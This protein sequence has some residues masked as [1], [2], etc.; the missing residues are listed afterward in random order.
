MNLLAR[1]GYKK[2]GQVGEAITTSIINLDPD[3]ATEAQ[4]DEL[5][6]KFKEMSIQLEE[7]NQSLK[8]EQ[9]EA[10]NKQKEYDKK[11]A[12]AMLLQQKAADATDPDL[13]ASLEKSLS[14]IVGELEEM[15]AD[16]AREKQEADDALALRDQLNEATEAMAKNLKEVRGALEQAKHRNRA[17]AAR[18]VAA[19]RSAEVAAQLA[20]IKQSGSQF[21]K[22]LN[23]LNKTADRHEAAA[24]AAATRANLL[25]PASSNDANIEAAMR[26]AGGEP[27]KADLAARL[28][29]L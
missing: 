8:K 27:P 7:A 21:N 22:V 15:K 26:E 24:N 23:T 20:G 4:I 2:L 28:A 6:A 11:K 13:K 14:T 19:E 17:A 10:I 12:A 9:A 5:D 3:T 1:M 16:V 29:N 25:K 18:E